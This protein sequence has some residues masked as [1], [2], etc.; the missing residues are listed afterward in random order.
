MTDATI[1]SSGRQPFEE[2]SLKEQVLS[3]LTT[4]GAILEHLASRAVAEDRPGAPS[5]LPIEDP[6]VRK[7]VA[8]IVTIL[9]ASGQ[10]D[11]VTRASD[12]AAPVSPGDHA[13]RSSLADIADL[14][15]VLTSICRTRGIPDDPSLLQELLE[16]VDGVCRYFDPQ[17]VVGMLVASRSA[18]SPAVGG[19]PA[20]D[21]ASADRH[22]C[23]LG[24]L[25]KLPLPEQSFS[26]G[27]MGRLVQA[28]GADSEYRVCLVKVPIASQD[29]S[30]Q[31]SRKVI[32][33]FLQEARCMIIAAHHSNAVPNPVLAYDT[34]GTPYLVMRFV[35]PARDA[36]SY[37]KAFLN[38]RD[39]KTAQEMK[40]YHSKIT[41][42]MKTAIAH[43]L[44]L[45]HPN[46]Q[47]LPMRVI[48]R[49]LKPSNILIKLDDNEEI[50]EVAIIDFG[51]AKLEPL[52]D[53]VGRPAES[54]LFADEY[55]SQLSTLESTVALH[56]APTQQDAAKTRMEDIFGTAGFISP[57]YL[58]DPRQ[59]GPQADIY[60]LGI[61]WYQMLTGEIPRSSRWELFRKYALCKHAM[62]SQAAA[63]AQR[64]QA[65]IFPDIDPRTPIKTPSDHDPAV[66]R[67]ISAIIMKMISLDTAQRYESCHQILDDIRN[68]ESGLPVR[69]YTERLG[70]LGRLAY[71]ARLRLV[72]HPMATG[73]GMM[74]AALALAAALFAYSLRAAGRRQAARAIATTR[75]VAQRQ[76]DAGEYVGARL[77]LEN[78]LRTAR[79]QGLLSVQ[80]AIGRDIHRVDRTIDVLRVLDDR[81][82]RIIGHILDI[83]DP[84]GYHSSHVADADA[85]LADLGVAD[86]RSVFTIIEQSK[87]TPEESTRLRRAVG[88]VYLGK[89]VRLTKPEIYRPK[90]KAELQR[91]T[92][93]LTMADKALNP[94][95]G[96][97]L[98]PTALQMA[99]VLALKADFQNEKA[100]KLAQNILSKDHSKIT[101]E[102]K[103][104]TMALMV[105][106]SNDPID[107][108]TTY[109]W[110]CELEG[111]D[112]SNKLLS[113]RY[114]TLWPL[115]RIFVVKNTNIEYTTM[116]QYNA[117]K[118]IL[119]QDPEH[120][121]ALTLLLNLINSYNT[122]FKV[123]QSE[124]KIIPTL[125]T[126]VERAVNLE[127]QYNDSITIRLQKL[128]R[129][130]FK[131]DVN[132]E[133]LLKET[134]RLLEI[135]ETIRKKFKREYR[136][137]DAIRFKAL[138]EALIQLKKANKLQA[139][140]LALRVSSH[141]E[142]SNPEIEKLSTEIKLLITK[143]L[144]G[145]LKDLD[146]LE[147]KELTLIREKYGPSPIIYEQLIADLMD[148]RKDPIII[149]YSIYQKSVDGKYSYTNAIN[150]KAL[151]ICKTL[152]AIYEK[153]PD[154]YNISQTTFR[155]LQSMSASARDNDE[156]YPLHKELISRYKELIK[157]QKERQESKH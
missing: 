16:N 152:L 13:A 51:L 86:D 101:A 12:M 149:L 22:F 128:K 69:A 78:A 79:D 54:D 155:H 18:P 100:Y 153:Y 85:F 15:T 65:E 142:S 150:F 140:L 137:I 73:A 46:S 14:S 125:P 102:D 56:A 47:R 132:Y 123:E 64:L 21:A 9:S 89:A 81:E 42:I 112:N 120:L 26:Q 23:P 72:S 32:N 127:E 96:D 6:A 103:F 147:A 68:Y 59:A 35:E 25:V 67:E 141:G 90:S 76:I 157:Q 109:K 74:L 31:E 63:E 122:I 139:K 113:T 104:L 24:S 19:P 53:G 136:H 87:L 80:T 107:V 144:K 5:P 92:K 34:E 43:M 55:L 61:T 118:Q 131:E 1:Q 95:Q 94:K 30:P 45:H 2:S 115:T 11:Q 135:D 110:L 88:L 4:L 126:A 33:R 77:S 124:L 52:T 49:D 37:Y 48:H 146:E 10:H 105:A 83:F 70:S 130:I 60:A 145:F 129:D 151:Q 119:S 40:I 148:L 114:P 111:N 7:H 8:N 93:L 62:S 138:L 41:N 27:G 20:G 28:D 71:R 58:Q 36:E 156:L 106:D 116:Y 143:A 84:R 99:N 44:A 66:P 154:R 117:I 97:R 29:S 134:N 91:A 98:Y 82:T 108:N 50:T 3:K 133:D 121:T 17:G 75:A 38:D 39:R 57:E